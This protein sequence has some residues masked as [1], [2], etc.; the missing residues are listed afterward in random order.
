MS[1]RCSGFGACW[2]Q[3]SVCGKSRRLSGSWGGFRAAASV[4]HW[5]QPSPNPLLSFMKG[6]QQRSNHHFPLPANN[7]SRAWGMVYVGV[8]ETVYFRWGFFFGHGTF[9]ARIKCRK[10]AW[11]LRRTKDWEMMLW[12]LLRGGWLA[13]KTSKVSAVKLKMRSF[14]FSI[15][16]TVHIF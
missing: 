2:P 11:K 9:L 16:V 15:S 1:S 4:S 12:V 13:Q 8:D 7:T 14:S 10:C 5:A 6:L 3:R